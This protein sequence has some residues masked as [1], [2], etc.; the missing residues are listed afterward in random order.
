MAVMMQ[1]DL[2]NKT[3]LEGGTEVQRHSLTEAFGV[4]VAA[5]AVCRMPIKLMQGSRL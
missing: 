3:R 2:Y 4:A 5:A 1:W